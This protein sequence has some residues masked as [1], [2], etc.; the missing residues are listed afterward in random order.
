MMLSTRA[1]ENAGLG[2]GG[3]NYHIRLKLALVRLHGYNLFALFPEAGHG[4]VLV[5][6]AALVQEAPGVRLHGALRL[7]VAVGRRELPARRFRRDQGNGVL[8]LIRVPPV[9][10][11]VELLAPVDVGLLHPLRLLLVH[12]DVEPARGVFGG[13]AELAGHLRPELERLRGKRH[14]GRLVCPVADVSAVTAGRLGAD[15][16]LL[17]DDGVHAV[18]REPPRRAKAGNAGP[19]DYYLCA[20]QPHGVPPASG[21]V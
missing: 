7:G 12:R 15:D 14:N 3:A 5:E 6:P 18:L 19:Y 4:G 16:A 2:A 11:D 9:E 10:R 8:H 20:V 21:P 13:V 1:G 17:H